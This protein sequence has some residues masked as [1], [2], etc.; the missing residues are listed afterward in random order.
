MQSEIGADDQGAFIFR[1]NS[2]GVFDERMRITHD[3]KVG[4]GTASPGTKLHISNGDITSASGISSNALLISDPTASRIYFEDTGEETDK[5]LMGITAFDQK[6]KIGSLNDIGNAWDQE[7]IA[8]FTR[9][10]KVGIGTAS[11]TGLLDLGSTYNAQS[12]F[13]IND[14]SATSNPYPSIAL[15]KR[16]CYC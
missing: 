3:G 9:D 5:K 2:G 7:N 4:I 6:L 13:Q 11:P 12:N 10:G 14:N 8:V 16:D 15:Q 1:P